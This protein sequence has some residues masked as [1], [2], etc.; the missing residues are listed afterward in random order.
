M[1]G[2]F[3]RRKSLQ[4][5]ERRDLG[6]PTYDSYLVTTCHRLHRKPLEDFTVE[7]L[8]IMIG[9]GFSLPI[10]IPLA[11]ERLEEDPLAEGDYYPGDLLSSVATIDEAFWT[12]HPG[13][14]QDFR[15]ILSSVRG[16]TPRLDKTDRET[17]RRVLEEATPL[18]VSK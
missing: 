1:K 7:D 14:L 2:A 16:L 13:S 6:E 4:E 10:L 18:V 15:A 12:A 11:L 9:Q 5:I 8:R 3:D 17:V